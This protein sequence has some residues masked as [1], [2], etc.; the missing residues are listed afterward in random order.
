LEQQLEAAYETSAQE[1]EHDQE[2]A[3]AVE[4]ATALEG[5]PSVYYKAAIGVL[6]G[7]HRRVLTP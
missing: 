7:C 2:L 3:E 6:R 5:F 4:E 1:H